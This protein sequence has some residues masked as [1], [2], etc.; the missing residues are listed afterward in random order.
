[1]KTIIVIL[2]LLIARNGYCVENNYTVEDYVIAIYH[3]EG[4]SR[5]FGVLSVP[6][7]GYEH[8][9]RICANTVRNNMRRYAEYGYKTYPDYLSFLASRYAPTKNATNDPQ[10]L[11]RFWIKNVRYFLANPR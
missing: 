9:R 5:P 3:A 11:N 8:C 1:M 7:S 2:I 10:N 4:G 6:C